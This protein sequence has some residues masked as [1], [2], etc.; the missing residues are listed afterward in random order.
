MSCA[1]ETDTLNA[2]LDG[3]L[4]RIKLHLETCESCRALVTI[5]Q[6]LKA[7]SSTITDEQTVQR[8]VSQARASARTPTLRLLAAAAAALVLAF[9]VFSF[10]SQDRVTAR[11]SHQ[12]GSVFV[13]H[14]GISFRRLASPE[15]N[16]ADGERLHQSESVFVTHRNL[17]TTT[18]YALVFA[19]DAKSTIHWLY[20]A[21]VSADSQ[22]TSIALA[23][24]QT[25]IAQPEAVELEDPAPGPLTFVAVMTESPLR[26][27]DIESL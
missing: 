18:A 24:S 13:R 25:E 20:P 17:G 5:A 10:L 22:E 11:G 12:S 3:D 19:V 21:H 27:T 15:V 23:P 9:P 1:H 2:L 7:P 4:R 26:V 14:V 8:L 6:K 16:I